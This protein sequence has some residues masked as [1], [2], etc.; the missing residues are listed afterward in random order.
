MGCDLLVRE[1]EVN[2]SE[3]AIHSL[4]LD[5]FTSRGRRTE[6]MCGF[7]CDMIVAV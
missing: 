6:N 3:C 7:S 5:V 2:V 4:Y 1:S